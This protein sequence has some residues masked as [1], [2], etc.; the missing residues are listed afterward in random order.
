MFSFFHLLGWCEGGGDTN[1]PL[2][3]LQGPVVR[4][5]ISANP[6]LNFSPGFYFF[7]SKF[8]LR[9]I[10]SIPLRLSNHQIVDKNDKTEFA[11]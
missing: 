3:S 1:L 7:C 10:F 9:V 4:K 11:F 5:P 8:F 2:P 6:G